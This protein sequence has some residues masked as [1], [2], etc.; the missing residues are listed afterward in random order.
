MAWKKMDYK[1]AKQLKDA[2]F[3]FKNV[4]ANEPCIRFEGKII[5][6]K[7]PTLEE[8]IDA[9]GLPISYGA[10]IEGCS[11]TKGDITT[12][13]KDLKTAVVKLYIK[14]NEKKEEKNQ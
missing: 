12:K 14:L 1:L 5:P 10:N 9:C 8:L 7:I 11:A 3:P 2:G 4:L 6:R 13:D